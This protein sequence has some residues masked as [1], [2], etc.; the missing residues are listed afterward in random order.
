VHK[1]FAALPAAPFGSGAHQRIDQGSF[2]IE[3]VGLGV[4]FQCCSTPFDRLQELPHV[5]PIRLPLMLLDPLIVV[6]TLED[7]VRASCPRAAC[8]RDDPRT[9]RMTRISFSGP[10]LSYQR[11]FTMA[12]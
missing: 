1:A 12:K 8:A 3:E 4:F 10:S 6:R 2:E 11:T 7:P 5:V 9:A